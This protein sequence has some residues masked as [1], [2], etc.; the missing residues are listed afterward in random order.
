[1]KRRKIL[2][3]KS[4]E[5]ASKNRTTSPL[6]PEQIWIGPLGQ[7]AFEE[8]V[9]LVNKILAKIK[10]AEAELDKALI[11]V[12]VGRKEDGSLFIN[13]GDVI[14][15]A[16]MRYGYR[17]F[18]CTKFRLGY[19]VG[20]YWNYRERAFDVSA[21]IELEAPAEAIV[22]GNSLPLLYHIQDRAPSLI[23]R[24]SPFVR[25]GKDIGESNWHSLSHFPTMHEFTRRVLAL[26][27]PTQP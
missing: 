22:L 23:E 13:V 14:A 5:S 4:I 12:R 16:S 19:P 26:I 15:A 10:D 2:T 24:K 20:Y 6:T 3:K 17:P 25:P 7:K 8:D 9:E 11:P 18:I 21:E 1:M 27:N